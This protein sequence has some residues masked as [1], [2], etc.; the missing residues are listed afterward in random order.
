LTA[1]ARMM[2]PDYET[3]SLTAAIAGVEV[4]LDLSGAM[5]IRDGEILVVSDL[6]FEKSS[7]YARGRQFLP[8]YDT[9]VTLNALEA[10]IRDF[11]PKTVICLGDSFHDPFC[12]ERLQLADIE[13]FGSLAKGRE[14]IWVEGNH[15]PEIPYMLA[16]ER[17]AELAIGPLTLRHLP[18]KGAAGIGEVAGHLHPAA[19]IFRRGRSVRRACFAT[20]GKR[21]IMPAFGALTGGLS[22]AHIAFKGL[23]DRETLTAYMLG[24]GQIHAIHAD[25]LS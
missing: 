24:A 9:K 23:F 20:D 13:R 19:R 4:V 17:V 11:A 1:Y 12:A 25:G 3:V 8:P 6:H 10:A 21:L 14:W 16:G 18:Q 7:S 5:F 2:N 22:L 15:D